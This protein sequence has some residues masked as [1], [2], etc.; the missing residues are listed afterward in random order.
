MQ[1][2]LGCSPGQVYL[3][4]AILTGVFRCSLITPNVLRV[5]SEETIV[6]DGQGTGFDADISIH[7]FPRK[8]FT[9]V[10]SRVSVNSNNQFFGS[11]KLTIPSANLEKDPNKKQFV[12]VTV[13]SPQCSLEKV[14]LVSFQ[15]GY[16]FIQ[17]DKPIY[18]PGS[19]VLYR[20]FTMTPNLKPV[21]KPVVIE[22][23]TPENVIVKKDIQTSETGI[24]SLSYKLPDLVS[25]GLW[26]ISAKFEDT[27]IQNYTTQFEV[28]EYVLPSFEI[29]IKPSQKYFYIKDEELT[30]NIEA[31]YLYGKPVNGKAFVIFGVKREKEK[32]SLPD[33]LRS[34]SVYKNNK[35]LE[36]CQVA[37]PSKKQIIT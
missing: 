22:F 5:D 25:L 19:T 8:R 31:K 30:V 13:N 28:K 12:Y 1:L 10:T 26:T 37:L 20:I 32:K 2:S 35:E 3:L 27:L 6:V 9:L 17:T 23:L 21:R 24:M 36:K 7:D 34:V 15:S 14:V 18:T 33:T 16:I 11:N 29:K 4:I